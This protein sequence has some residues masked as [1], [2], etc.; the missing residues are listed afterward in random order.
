MK[1]FIELDSEEELKNITFA[2]LPT[3]S[4]P[5]HFCD[6]SDL[7]Y[8][9][10]KNNDYFD[11]FVQEQGVSEKNETR[12]FS[13]S[14]VLQNKNKLLLATIDNTSILKASIKLESTLLINHERFNNFI[15]LFEI[16]ATTLHEAFKKAKSCMQYVEI[17]S[18]LIEFKTSAHLETLIESYFLAKKDQA[19]KPDP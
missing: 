15:T 4:P 3:H 18:C 8:T 7:T 10:T 17:N 19:V 6:C 13:L 5:F 16:H 11:V 2:E 12:L 9:F 14:Q 1:N